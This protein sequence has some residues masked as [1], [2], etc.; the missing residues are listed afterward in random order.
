MEE[1]DINTLI[2]TALSTE[3]INYMNSEG[4]ALFKKNLED[5][6]NDNSALKILLY[7]FPVN[8][9]LEKNEKE[10]WFMKYKDVE[11]YNEYKFSKDL[12]QCYNQYLSDKDSKAFDYNVLNKIALFKDYKFITE[13]LWVLKDYDYDAIIIAIFSYIEKDPSYF[14]KAFETIIEPK[15]IQ[16]K[17]CINIIKDYLER[18]KVLLDLEKSIKMVKIYSNLLENEKASKK[19]L[20]NDMDYLKKEI[21]ELKNNNV[22]L[23]KNISKLQKDNAELRNDNATLNENISELRNDNATLNENISKL[24]N[25]NA[26]LNENISGMKNDI[27]ELKDRLDQIDTRDTVKMSLRYLYKMLF[28]Q[29]SNEMKSVTQIWEQIDEVKKILSKPQ[30]KRFTYVSKFIDEINWTGLKNLN[31]KAHDSSQKERNFKGIEKYFKGIPESVT[32]FVANFFKGLPNVNEFINLNL[33]FY[34]DQNIVDNE[35]EKIKTYKDAYIAVFGQK[36]K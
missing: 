9:S 26:T 24:R 6:S 21:K 19:N 3:N 14:A 23:N 32:S 2:N 1:S 34:K 8:S 13:F 28:T 31:D 4:M 29:F 36:L 15:N 20:I 16:T 5:K 22:T 7:F 25:D 35:F 18:K 33:L 30:F 12:L 10:F 11:N 17:A 27:S